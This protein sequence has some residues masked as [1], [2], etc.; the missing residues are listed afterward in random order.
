MNATILAMP[1][2]IAALQAWWD[3]TRSWAQGVTSAV[4]ADMLDE[5]GYSVPLRANE[6]PI[7]DYMRS[8]YTV[9]SGYTPGLE[10]FAAAAGVFD[11]ARG[12]VAQPTMYPMV[13]WLRIGLQQ[14]GLYPVD[15]LDG[16]AV[17]TFNGGTCSAPRAAEKCAST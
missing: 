14:R 2:V 9:E 17:L 8:V 5:L 7:Q 3:E 6:H 13:K 15:T 16:K 1:D 12:T 11:L 4:I 10:L